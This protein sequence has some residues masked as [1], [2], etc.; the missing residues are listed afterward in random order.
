M[1]FTNPQRIINKQFDSFV[2]S[3]KN[4]TNNVATSV[5]Q[6]RQQVAKQKEYTKKLEQA[7]Q[8]EGFQLR[9]KLNEV[10]TT[11]NK[12]LDE[13]IQ[14]FW[15][16]K[17]DDYFKIKNAMQDGTITKQ[18]G[19]RG[20]SQIM[21]LVP[22]FKRQ[23]QIIGAQSAAFKEDAAN[24]NVSSIGSIENK[25]FLKR[26]GQ[27]GNIGIVERGGQL[28]FFAPE[29]DGEPASMINGNELLT[30][31]NSGQNM[32]QT[33][34]NLTEPGT[35]IFNKIIQPE[36]LE[37]DFVE[38][39]PVKK[40]DI[41]PV[42]GKPIQNLEDGKIYSYRT[43]KQDKKQGAIEAMQ[44]SPAISSMIGND[45][46]MKRVWQDEIPDEEIERIAGEQG[47]DTSLYK[48]GWHEYT[49]NMSEDQISKINNEQNEIM[50]IYLAN[51][52]YND[53]ATMDNTLKY[54]KEEVINP[55]DTNEKT[56]EPY[57]MDIVN[58]T[59][60]FFE[61]PLENKNLLLNHSITSGG[62][63]FNIDN[64]RVQDD[65][66]FIE[67]EDYQPVDEETG[68]P[69]GKPVYKVIESFNMKDPSQQ[70]V[71]AQDLQRAAGGNNKDNNEVI[72]MF[73][74]L[75]PEVYKKR[76]VELSKTA[77]KNNVPTGF[78]FKDQKAYN[79][80]KDKHPLDEEGKQYLRTNKKLIAAQA[81]VDAAGIDPIA[82]SM[83]Q[84]EFMELEYEIYQEALI[85]GSL[86]KLQG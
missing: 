74:R 73:R 51:K 77:S 11:G 76:Q 43:I 72:A 55:T 49:Q 78:A 64:I 16:E 58:D 54:V 63:T 68:E 19:N 21:A 18:E 81:A 17:V 84:K 28:Y 52:F 20:L 61:N 15:N 79:N 56:G 6:M 82:R 3:S 41:N 22:Q 70:A 47:F 62:K 25:S 45:N 34:P 2:N 66:V 40:G 50:K 10:G 75:Y 14:A 30:M 69:V 33:K 32:Y 31:E 44:K 39:I 38:T 12:V 57:Y 46:L 53:N 36:S 65:M 13:N 67:T 71:L 7:D 9:S 4:I 35:A 24:G 1:S 8:Q 42:T 48:D 5:E 80:W 23:V 29:E 86:N 85:Q 37:S 59:V 83:A 60:S 27:G 26:A